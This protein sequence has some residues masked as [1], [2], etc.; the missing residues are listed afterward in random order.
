MTEDVEAIAGTLSKAQHRNLFAL[1]DDVAIWAT[2]SE[3][4]SRGATGAGMDVLHV[5]HRPLLSERRWVTWG[6]ER[7]QLRGEGYEYRITPHG[8]AVR[9]FLASKE[10]SGG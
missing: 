1:P 8:L 6:G 10:Q 3:M 7:G 9:S 4:R 2:V 5:F